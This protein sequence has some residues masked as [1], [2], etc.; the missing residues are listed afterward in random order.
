MDREH[1]SGP[2]DEKMFTD[3]LS[4]GTECTLSKSAGDTRLGGV[5]LSL[6][7][8][9]CAEGPGQAGAMGRGHSCEVQQ[10]SVPGPALVSQQP[11]TALQAGAER[12]E[13]AWWE[14]AWG[15]WSTAGW[16]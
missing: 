16:A 9:G 13:R 2:K 8:A 14:R 7:Q 6:G 1:V 10:G 3:D 5:L 15:C 12:L 11:H 4:E